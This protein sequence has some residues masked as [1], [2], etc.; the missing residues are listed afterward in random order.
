MCFVIFWEK[1]QLMSFF[2][3][4]KNWRSKKKL[5]SFNNLINTYFQFFIRLPQNEHFLA[6]NFCKICLT[7]VNRIQPILERLKENI[8]KPWKPSIIDRSK[9]CYHIGIHSNSRDG[10]FLMPMTSKIN[11]LMNKSVLFWKDV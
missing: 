4:G 7:L 1:Q 11:P 5:G 6:S 2:I 9:W 3:Q 8:T 10:L